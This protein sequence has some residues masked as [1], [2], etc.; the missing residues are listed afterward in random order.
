MSTS[1]V[2]SSTFA[3]SPYQVH[4]RGA[5]AQSGL[6]KQA[7]LRHGR[8]RF[9]SEI[10]GDSH[11]FSASAQKS[12]E[13]QTEKQ[14]EV[15]HLGLM[16]RGWKLLTAPISAAFKAIRSGLKGILVSMLGV[17]TLAAFNQKKAAAAVG[18]LSFITVPMYAFASGVGRLFRNIKEAITGRHSVA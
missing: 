10:E 15:K 12:P 13:H 6:N 9:S 16:A 3:S 4:G 1:F 2:S 14:P 5:S 8:I 17:G 18:A 7:D 11:S